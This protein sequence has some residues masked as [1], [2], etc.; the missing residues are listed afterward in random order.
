MEEGVL[1]AR[2]GDFPGAAAAFR[3]VIEAAGPG[4]PAA[5]ALRRQ[6]LGLKFWGKIDTKK[7]DSEAQNTSTNTN[8]VAAV[9]LGRGP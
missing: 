1:L 6:T 3:A 5:E 4:S 8:R 7:H 9:S 2:E